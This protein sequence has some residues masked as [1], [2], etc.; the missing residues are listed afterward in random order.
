[1]LPEKGMALDLGGIA[2]GY[3]GD[4]VAAELRKNGI[5]HAIADLGGNLFVI[6]GKPDG[7]DW[8][9]G[10]QTPFKPRGEYFGIL[11]VSDKAVVT[12][13][14]YERY[15]EENGKTYH[16]IMDTKTGYP[17]DNELFSVTVVNDSSMAADALAKAFTMGLTDGMK[18]IESTKGAEAIFVTKDKKVYLTPGLKG[19]FKITDSN[20]KLY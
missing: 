3:A 19:K 18:F 4:A 12:S 1:M 6:G 9:V 14:I 16:H 15:F 11:C 5:K 10:I 13:G 17:I 8:N 20:Y 7:T 2:K